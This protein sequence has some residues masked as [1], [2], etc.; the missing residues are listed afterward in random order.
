[1]TSYNR[2]ISSSRTGVT[3]RFGIRSSQQKAGTEWII[4]FENELVMPREVRASLDLRHHGGD[5]GDLRLPDHASPEAR[6]NDAGVVE[7][8]FGRY[9]PLGVEEGQTRRGAAAARRAVHFAVGEHRDVALGDA[10]PP[11]VPFGVFEEDGAVDAPQPG[12]QRVGDLGGGVQVVVDLPPDLDEARHV[13][14][15]D[16]ELQITRVHARV[17][18]T[19]ERDVQDN[20]TRRPGPEGEAARVHEGGHVAEADG[21]R[22]PSLDLCRD[23]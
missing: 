1:M 19:P 20:L 6:P 10:G 14:G 21:D 18:G 17:E 12:L 4:F 9:S 22:P 5:A 15:L 2:L 23:G 16:G 13:G 3:A 8:L 11:A 7:D